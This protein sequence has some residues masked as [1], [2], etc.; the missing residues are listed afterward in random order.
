MKVLLS[1]AA[2]LGFLAISVPTAMATSPMPDGCTWVKTGPVHGYWKC[3]IEVPVPVEPI[4]DC[5]CIPDALDVLQT[6]MA[7]Q[8]AAN[9]VTGFKS[10]EDV[11]QAAT[12]IANVISIDLDD[13]NLGFLDQVASGYQAATN[14]VGYGAGGAKDVSQEA[15]NAVNLISVET[16]GAVDQA[17]TVAQ[18]AINTVKFEGPGYYFHGI[19]VTDVSQDATNVANVASASAGFFTFESCDCIE[20][21]QTATA[22]QTAMNAIYGPSGYM[23]KL[24]GATQ[25]ATNI[26]NILSG[27][28]GE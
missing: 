23:S 9:K 5:D 27:S 10:V 28:A 20:V 26:A 17:S 21:T 14:Y 25:S 1:T 19:N 24:N 2:A 3:T 12:N 6:I 8:V 18:A 7:K 22:P 4:S 11:T 13:V 16:L 15:L